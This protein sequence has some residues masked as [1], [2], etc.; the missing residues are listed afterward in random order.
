MTPGDINARWTFAA[1]VLL[2]L[3]LA[4]AAAR[5]S[6]GARAYFDAGGHLGAAANGIAISAEFTSAA[7]LLGVIAL[8]YDFGAD[9]LLYL[10]STCVGF[11]F[12]TLVMAERYRAMGKVTMADVL[13]T[14]FDSS[15]LRRFSAVSSLA[16]VAGYLI[17]QLATGS[18]LLSGLFGIGYLAALVAITVLAAG[19]VAVGGMLAATWIQMLKAALFVS[20]LTLL[21]AITLDAAGWNGATLLSRVGEAHRLGAGWAQPGTM[22]PGLGATLS[23]ALT[24]AFGVAGLPHILIRFC[25]VPDPASARRSMQFATLIVCLVVA[26]YFVVAMGAIATV[27]PAD[28]RG[29]SGSNLVFLEYVRV[30]AGDSVLGVVAA[31]VF[32]TI[33]AVV[34]GLV[35]AAASALVRDLLPGGDRTDDRRALPRSRIASVATVVCGALLALAFGDLKL[36]FVMTLAFAV[37]ASANFPVLLLALRWDGLSE[38]GAWAGGVIGLASAVVFAIAGPTIWVDVLGNA[39]PLFPYREP[40]I[41]AM[42]AAF[43]A[44]IMISVLDNRRNASAQPAPMN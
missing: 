3:V 35:L 28:V 23:L 5:R 22:T 30:I 8:L 10:T 16:V 18:H 37:A 14:R 27:P 44:A 7:S 34:A 19:F 43:V 41:V 40:A 1:V 29:S 26:T 33:L 32:A 17:A 6:R 21:A 39:A 13:A 24:M 9:A 25:T 20:G 11:A 38:G 36:G 31:G 12:V 2:A 4:V 15:R 42:P